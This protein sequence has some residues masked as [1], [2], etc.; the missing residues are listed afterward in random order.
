M[1]KAGS[2]RLSGRFKP[3]TEVTLIKARD[4]ERS[5]RSQGGEQVGTAKVD[6]D[7]TVEWTTGVHAGERYFATGYVDGT[8]L[9]VRLTGREKGDESSVVTQPPIGPDRV[10]LSDGSFLDEPPE[11]HQDT[12]KHEVGPHLGQHQV[13]KGVIQRSDTPRGSAHP[14]DPAEQTPVRRQEDVGDTVVQM[15]A[16]ETGQAT[17]IVQSV[18]RQ[19]DAHGILQRSDTPHGVATPIPAGDAV[20][21]QLAKESSAG[22]ESRGEPVKAAREPLT[23]ETPV[24]KAAAKEA[25]NAPQP[26]ATPGA[27][28]NADNRTGL[29]A[30][31]Q[32]LYPDAAAV[33]GVSPAKK[34]AEAQKKVRDADEAPDPLEHLN[35]PQQ[36]AEASETED[37]TTGAGQDKPSGEVD[38]T[39]AKRRGSGASKT[40]TA[41]KEK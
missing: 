1:A 11:Q 25:G 2:A 13:P 7:G 29:D 19:E 36:D 16:T 38:V 34:P 20:Q 23:G 33:A 31:G 3:G 10:R 17:E 12:P 14:V 27:P 28:S 35:D 30:M 40:T 21:A 15:S 26:L 4:G 18:Q 6:K 41:K 8:Y 37:A 22:K 24:R 9:E 5:L 39:K 32:P